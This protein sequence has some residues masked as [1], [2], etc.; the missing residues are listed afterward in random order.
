MIIFH[1]YCSN[2]TENH[3]HSQI[4]K[5]AAELLSVVLHLLTNLI[6]STAG[7]HCDFVAI[8]AKPI[9]FSLQS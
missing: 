1:L 2:I 6:I 5:P 9:Y 8:F 7:L 4:F 3:A